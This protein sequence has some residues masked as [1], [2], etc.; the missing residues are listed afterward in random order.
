MFEFRYQKDTGAWVLLETNARFWG[1]LPLPLSLGVDF[2]RLLYDLLVHGEEHAPREYRNGIRSRNLVLDGFNLIGE[3][4]RGRVNLATI[5]NYL[6]QPFG[7][8][9]GRER[10][11]SFVRDDLKP[12]FWECVHALRGRPSPLRNRRRSDRRE[13]LPSLTKEEASAA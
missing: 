13:A 3:A 1:S 12:A 5:A 7:W 10:S 11:D 9:S 2:P 8:I 4:R 6:G